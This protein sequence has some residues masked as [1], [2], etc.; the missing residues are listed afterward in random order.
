MP[1]LMT[2]Q[3]WSAVSKS[4]RLVLSRWPVE[5]LCASEDLTCSAR[6]IHRTRFPVALCP[7]RLATKCSCWVFFQ[8]SAPRA[9]LASNAS[10]HASPK[11]W[12]TRTLQ[13]LCLGASIWPDT[14]V[15]RAWSD[16]TRVISRRNL[17]LSGAPFSRITIEKMSRSLSWFCT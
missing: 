2:W 16:T 5:H 11:I 12:S 6:S 8:A 1:L 14:L 15:G 10:M 7:L 3:L 13:L 17:Q 4:R 9:S